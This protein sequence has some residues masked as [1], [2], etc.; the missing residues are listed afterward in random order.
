MI[1]QRFGRLIVVKDSGVRKHRKVFWECLCD[2]GK[3][4]IIRTSNLTSGTAKSCGCLRYES[5]KGKIRK[6]RKPSLAPRKKIGSK[7]NRLTIIDVIQEIRNPTIAI[8]QCEC[9]NII[10][11][12]YNEVTKYKVKSCGCLSKERSLNA[13]LKKEQRE[14]EKLN[15][16]VEFKPSKDFTNK[17]YGKLTVLYFCGVRIDKK[18]IKHSLW[19]CR[20]DCGKYIIKRSTSFQ[21]EK[22]SCGCTYR[23]NR[24]KRANTLNVKRHKEREQLIGSGYIQRDIA[25][26][27]NR[28]MRGTVRNG[29]FEKHGD[30]CIICH[31]GDSNEDPLCIHH[32]KPHWMYPKLR[33]FIIN[34]IPLCRSCHD[35]LH[36]T[37][38]YI[39]P[40]MSEQIEFIKNRQLS[41]QLIA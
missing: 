9:G 27:K 5:H 18:E 33:Y 15:R 4:T 20:C 23:E 41:L 39:N 22:I 26:H 40:S 35:E 7:F 24:A 19:Y 21:N 1:G 37:L 2:C 30:N 11:K 38:G 6:D 31:K 14:L 34:N 32:L 25:D 29:V 28:R 16:L 36:K 17:K 8:C 3:V 13:K 12:P 10:N